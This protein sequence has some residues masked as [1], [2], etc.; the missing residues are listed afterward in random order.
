MKNHDEQFGQAAHSNF[1]RGVYKCTGE[2]RC[3]GGRPGSCSGGLTGAPCAQ[4]LPGQAWS[5]E[6]CVDCD[7][8]TFLVGFGNHK[9]IGAAASYGSRKTCSLTGTCGC[10]R[11][12]AK[13]E[14][15]VGSTC[16]TWTSSLDLTIGS[17]LLPFP[18]NERP[19]VRTAIWWV[20][21]TVVL[22]ST[23]AACYYFTNPTMAAQASPIQAGGAAF[24]LL[25]L[26]VQ[27]AAR[28]KMQR[29]I[30]VP[31]NMQEGLGIF[32]AVHILTSKYTISMRLPSCH[33]Y[34]ALFN[35]TRLTVP[36]NYSTCAHTHT[37]ITPVFPIPSVIGRS[38]QKPSHVRYKA[39][40]SPLNGSPIGEHP[41]F[42]HHCMAPELQKLRGA[43]GLR[44]VAGTC[45]DFGAACGQI[46][47]PQK[48]GMADC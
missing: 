39:Y 34:V 21:V 43:F 32:S 24:A 17:I 41:G 45:S 37:R 7:V 20:S 29:S 10:R 4:C 16:I 11:T 46:L 33:I 38:K 14:E 22:P 15:S 3:P 13:M 30:V 28:S 36:T 9:G 2:K 26:L 5:D 31:Q 1:H 18:G 47:L 42:D 6:K 48:R 19:S 44:L 23:L 25:I 27:T 12:F 40:V 35:T 8:A